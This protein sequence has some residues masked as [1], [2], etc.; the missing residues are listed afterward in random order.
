M[1]LVTMNKTLKIILLSVSLLLLAGGSLAIYHFTTN[2]ADTVPVL[3]ENPQTEDNSF[4]LVQD[5]KIVEKEGNLDIEIIYPSFSGLDDFNQQVETFV[6]DYVTV[7]KE[8]ADSYDWAMEDLEISTG[9]KFDVTYYLHANYDKGRFDE[10][11]LSFV[12]KAEYYSGGAHGGRDF[13]S[14]AYDVENKKE[15]KLGDLFPDQSN[16]LNDIS[17]Y[18]FDDLKKQMTE[19]SG[20]EW[21]DEEWLIDGVSPDEENFQAFV[22]NEDSIAFYFPPYQVAAYAYGDFMVV[23]PWNREGVQLVNPASTNCQ[24]KGGEIF[25][26]ENSLGQY[27]VCLFEDNRQCEEWALYYGYCPVGG[28]KI[29]GYEYDSEVYCA[30]LGGKT[31]AGGSSCTFS[32][33]KVCLL[34][35]MS[36]GLCDRNLLSSDDELQLYTYVENNLSRLSPEPEVLGGKFYITRL[37]ILDVNYAEIEYE[38][39]HV[40]LKASFDFKVN[41]NGVTVENFVIIK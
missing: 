40:A 6:Q 10:K 34:D 21:V 7:F 3:D 20:D 16:Y 2:R 38:D 29:T 15:I 24:E 30:I 33:N 41:S 22:F 13:F 1:I 39:G 17:Q 25:I 4:L 23:F 14:F 27:G 9:E 35:D 18:C 5:K 19:K 28:V 12:L 31:T 36:Q 11:Y 26:K 37:E 8:N 32:N